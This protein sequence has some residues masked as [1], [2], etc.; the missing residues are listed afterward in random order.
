MPFEPDIIVTDPGSSQVL[1]IVE[2]KLNDSSPGSEEQL[3]RYMREMGC[4]IG[5]FVSPRSIALFRN[6]FTAQ[7]SIQKLGGYPTPTNWEQFA[8]PGRGA[9]FESFIQTWLERLSE[10]VKPSDLPHEAT[11]ALTR[12]VL[13]ALIA[14]EI[15]AAG[16]R[17][18]RA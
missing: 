18:L 7:D 9:E 10:G 8:R 2:A 4:P 17:R 1:L 11:D 3:G 13:P 16:P 14:G 15:R 12:H 5:L 6:L